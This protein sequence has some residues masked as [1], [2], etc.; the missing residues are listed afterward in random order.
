MASRL[1]TQFAFFFLGSTEVICSPSKVAHVVDRIALDAV[2]V[3]WRDESH[4]VD[5]CCKLPFQTFAHA[6]GLAA[7]S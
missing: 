1:S 5:L 3:A 6:L 2:A 4:L 7:Q